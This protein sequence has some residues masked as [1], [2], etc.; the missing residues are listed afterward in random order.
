[1]DQL[2]LEG[3]RPEPLAEVTPCAG[4]ATVITEAPRGILLH[5]YTYDPRG[6]IVEADVITP[7]AFNAAS[8]EDHFRAAVVGGGNGDDAGLKHR[9]EMIAR[10]YD[11]CISC[12]VHLVRRR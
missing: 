12:S 4:T 6:I 5:S 9:L 8:I 1:V 2:L 10:A 11:P 3:I 7:T